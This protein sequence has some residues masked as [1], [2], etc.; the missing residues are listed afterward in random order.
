MLS[1]GEILVEPSADADCESVDDLENWEQVPTHE[2][3]LVN[4][5]NL[6]LR[7]QKFIREFMVLILSRFGK[8]RMQFIDLLVYACGC[9]FPA[10]DSII[11]MINKID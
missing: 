7:A 1:Y 6:E 9:N 8:F 10:S 11:E 3:G 2:I 4:N 5:E